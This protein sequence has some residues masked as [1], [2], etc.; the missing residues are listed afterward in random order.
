MSKLISPHIEHAIRGYAVA[1]GLIVERFASDPDFDSFDVKW[2][3]H[4]SDGSVIKVSL[5][6]ME[7]D[8]G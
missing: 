4:L 8:R 2:V 3:A 6:M 5:R 7:P 1:N